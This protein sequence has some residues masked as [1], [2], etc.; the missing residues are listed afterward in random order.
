MPAD[1]LAFARWCGKD[2][3]SEAEWEYAASGGHDG[4]PGARACAHPG[5]PGNRVSLP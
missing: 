2:L 4:S 1:V 3:P 5:R